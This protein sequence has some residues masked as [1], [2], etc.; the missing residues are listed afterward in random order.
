[1]NDAVSVVV[2]ERLLR[3]IFGDTPDGIRA[4]A[5]V[6][7][8]EF[9]IIEVAEAGSAIVDLGSRTLVCAAFGLTC[10]QALARMREPGGVE[11]FRAHIAKHPKLLPLA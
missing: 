4:R 1:M 6:Y 5:T 3:R 9:A 2:S 10:E 8:N 7:R 11:A